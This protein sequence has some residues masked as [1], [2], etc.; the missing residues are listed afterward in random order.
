MSD[1]RVQHDVL[2][3]ENV[4]PS[5]DLYITVHTSSPGFQGALNAIRIT[6]EPG[7]LVLFCAAAPLVLAR[8]RRTH[9]GRP[10]VAL[11]T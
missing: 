2:R 1:G 3:W 9:P 10:P 4:S 11:G 7:M 6:P 5:G 8:R